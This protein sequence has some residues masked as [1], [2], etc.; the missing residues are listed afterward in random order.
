MGLLHHHH[1]SEE[2]SGSA[3]N[4]LYSNTKS[5]QRSSANLPPVLPERRSDKN[6][7]TSGGAKSE[8]IL[9]VYGDEDYFNNEPLV[10]KR[11]STWNIVPEIFENWLYFDLPKFEMNFLK[12]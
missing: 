1:H 9:A 11:V 6:I 5:L 3:D 12:K 7:R 4:H 2:S 8:A 10:Q